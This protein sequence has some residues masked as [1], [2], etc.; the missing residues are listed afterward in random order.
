MPHPVTDRPFT[1]A[2]TERR[3]DQLFVVLLWIHFAASLLLSFWYQTLPA[4][5]AIGLPAALI[6]TLLARLCPG[7]VV[8][9]CTAAAALMVFSA[10][11]I[12]QTHGLTETHFHIFCALAF[13]LA[14][15]DWR[16]ILTAALTIAIHHAVFTALQ[17][18]HIPVYIYTSDAV[19]AWSL[20]LIHA[21]FVVFESGMLIGLAVHMRSEWQQ[22]EEL[23]RLTQ[24]LA[25]GRLTGDDLTFRLDWPSDSRLAATAGALDSLLERLR[26]RIHTA[27]DETRQILEDAR[28]AAR[29]TEEIKLGGESVHEAVKEISTG[30]EEQ[31]RQTLQA[32][33]GMEETAGM[34]QRLADE[35]RSQTASVQQMAL[36]IKALRE[37]IGCIAATS[38][39]QAEAAGSARIAAMQGVDTVREASRM[40]QTVVTAVSEKVQYLGQRS[41]EIG[42]FA[43]TISHIANQTNLLALNAA[44]EAARAGEHGRGFA[45]VAE[46]VRKL[47]DHS[48]TAAREIDALIAVVRSEIEAVLRL[49]QGAA[50]SGEEAQSEFTRVAAMTEA[51]VA[52]GER[53]AML[54][55]RIHT[56]TT[57]NQ[58]AAQS[59]GERGEQVEEQIT[60]LL[61]HIV[62]HDQT[63]T[64]MAEQVLAAQEGMTQIAAITE[65]NSAAAHDVT[66]HI[67]SQFQALARLAQI[68]EQVAASAEGVCISLNRFQTKPV[69]SGL[70]SA[71][72]HL[73]DPPLSAKPL[74]ASMK[75][76][77]AA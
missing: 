22:A 26:S 17:T 36:L 65:Q 69:D 40:T 74:S 68:S 5:L 15:R 57:E 21:G 28:L 29:E 71:D 35:T 25:D 19:G 9:R 13:L 59:I 10:L 63:A 27:K 30:A 31:A 77:K 18:I 38:V 41:G 23:S 39:E 66:G 72:R 32:A 33:T 61:V 20:T 45:V 76:D 3:T 6:V 55:G 48:A 73:E 16:V 37:E 60:D 52:D 75:R 49:T 1:I 54:A 64:R 56:L 58:Q 42:A 14:Y 12:Q 8:V 11:F 70:F 47:A 50:Q 43:E 44:I 7:S 67:A 24:V 62:S 51:V 34:A 4:A 2:D 53:T 46:E